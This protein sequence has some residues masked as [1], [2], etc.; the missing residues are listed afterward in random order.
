MVS[1][2]LTLSE[3]RKYLLPLEWGG[4]EP[5][6]ELSEKPSDNSF[7][8]WGRGGTPKGRPPSPLWALGNSNLGSP[9]GEEDLCSPGACLGLPQLTGFPSPPKWAGEMIGGPYVGKHPGLVEGTTSDLLLKPHQGPAGPTCSYPGNQDQG[10]VC[11][12][13][14]GGGCISGLHALLPPG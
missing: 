11:V 9:G 12:L 4:G 1:T 7:W 6:S 2:Y 3:A 10:Q 13:G 5:Q 14:V 8:T